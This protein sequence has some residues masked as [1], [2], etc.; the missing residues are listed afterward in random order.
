MTNVALTRVFRLGL[1][2]IE[3]ILVVRLAGVVSVI[4]HSPVK[5]EASRT[6]QQL[7]GSELEEKQSTGT[8]LMMHTMQRRSIVLKLEP[9]KSE[10]ASTSTLLSDSDRV[11][12]FACVCVGLTK[13]TKSKTAKQSS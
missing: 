11:L 7:T 9:P 3:H 6:C 10:F 4:L 1:R 8:R 5:V 2:I 12:G 13:N